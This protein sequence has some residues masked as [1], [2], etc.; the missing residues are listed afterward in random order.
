GVAGR[1]ARL[2][3]VPAVLPGGAVVVLELQAD[4]L[5]VDQVAGLVAEVGG[6]VVDGVAGG[7]GGD[8]LAGQAA[9]P[10][11]REP[12]RDAPQVAHQRRGLVRVGVRARVERL[13]GVARQRA[14]V[15][16]QLRARPLQP[17]VENER[18]A[19][20]GAA[21]TARGRTAARAAAGAALLGGEVGVHGAEA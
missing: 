18:V 15:D 10:R 13:Q 21:R 3:A 9:G 7:D 6:L 2:G 16:R 1:G 17:L 19:L 11:G 12:V 8:L 14:G 5:G 4:H 20:A